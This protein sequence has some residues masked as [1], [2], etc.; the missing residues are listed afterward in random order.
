MTSRQLPVPNRLTSFGH[1]RSAALGSSVVRPREPLEPTQSP[2]RIQR[3]EP[4]KLRQRYRKV[5]GTLPV[6]ILI[7][8]QDHNKRISPTVSSGAFLNQKQYHYSVHR[9]VMKR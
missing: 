4:A 5:Y 8:Y 7:F 6:L 1:R 2:L 9:G 3:T